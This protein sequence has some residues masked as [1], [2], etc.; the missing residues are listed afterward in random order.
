LDKKQARFSTGDIIRFERLVSSIPLPELIRLS[1]NVPDE[2][3]GAAAKLRCASVYNINLG[4]NR[5]VSDKHWIY[6][7]EPTWLF[8]RIGFPH[9]FSPRQAPAG[10][11]SIYLEIAYSD[12]MPL[13]KTTAAKIA[14]RQLLEL[15]ILKTTDEILAEFCLDIPC[16]YV[17]YDHNYRKSMDLIHEFLKQHEVFLIGRYGAWEYTSMEDAIWQGAEMARV[18]LKQPMDG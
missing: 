17:I 11:G 14:K 16:A 13:E 10:C 7:P 2:I 12:N 18:I 15:G 5:D 9:N 4:I 3:R 6:V 1:A 8:Y